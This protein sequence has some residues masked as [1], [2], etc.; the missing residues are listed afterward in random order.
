M[1][2]DIIIEIRNNLTFMQIEEENLIN[3]PDPQEIKEALWFME[4][5]PPKTIG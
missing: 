4:H 3:C 2:D 5:S 1:Q